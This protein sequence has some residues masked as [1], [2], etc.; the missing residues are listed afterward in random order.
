[1]YVRKG[2]IDVITKIYRFICIALFHSQTRRRT[3]RKRHKTETAKN[4][5]KF[6][7]HF[8]SP[9]HILITLIC[10]TLIC[11]ESVGTSI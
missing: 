4:Q 11:Q 5:L 1:M 8:S 9:Q 6:I 7:K 2:V 3:A 10:Q